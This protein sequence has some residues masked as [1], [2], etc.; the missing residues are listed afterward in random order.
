MACPP[1]IAVAMPLLPGATGWI[2]DET[3]VLI[4]LPIHPGSNSLYRGPIQAISLLAANIWSSTRPEVALFPLPV[5]PAYGRG[6]A[7]GSQHLGDPR[8][9]PA[10]GPKVQPRVR[11]PYNSL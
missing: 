2:C 5:E 10:V 1:P 6:D 11:Q 4:L 3:G 9:D 8:D 7:G